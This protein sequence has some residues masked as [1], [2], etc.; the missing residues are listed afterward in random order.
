MKRITEPGPG[1]GFEFVQ[2]YGLNVSVL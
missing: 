2:T 1:D